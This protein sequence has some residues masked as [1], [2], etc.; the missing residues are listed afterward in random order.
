MV[1]RISI[2][3]NTSAQSSRLSLYTGK[4][5]SYLIKNNIPYREIRPGSEHYE[6]HVLPLAS[7][8]FDV[9]GAEGILRPAMHYRWNFGEE[10]VEYINFN[11]T[12]PGTIRGIYNSG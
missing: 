10:N 1:V 7:G 12:R 9:I 11:F 5:R 3:E 8:L 6:D 2:N 4:A